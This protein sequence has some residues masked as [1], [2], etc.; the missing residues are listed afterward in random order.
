MSEPPEQ[1]PHG[2]HVTAKGVAITIAGGLGTA[3]AI[4]AVMDFLPGA[5]SNAHADEHVMDHAQLQQVQQIATSNAVFINTQILAQLYLRAERLRA[6]VASG[7][8]T[9][10]EPLANAEVEIRRREALLV[11][12]AQK[13]R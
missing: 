13:T 6:A 5:I 7:D 4:W 3:L 2:F 8:T 10:R 9:A 12:T 11:A 1:K